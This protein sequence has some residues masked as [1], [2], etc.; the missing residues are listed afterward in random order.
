MQI[1]VSFSTFKALTALRESENDSV[2]DVIV[3]LLGHPIDASNLRNNVFQMLAEGLFIGGVLFPNGT[4]FRAQ[5]KGR[6]FT[7]SIVDGIWTDADGMPRNSPSEAASAIS[8]TNVNGWRF[9]E[10]HLPNSNEWIL[11]DRLRG[12]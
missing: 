8:N 4:Q 9:W 5:Y 11:L 1:D 7:A 10:A 2:D 12:K 3:R 6:Q